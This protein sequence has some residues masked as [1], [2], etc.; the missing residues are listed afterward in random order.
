MIRPFV[1]IAPLPASLPCGA[2]P[3]GGG[4]VGADNSSSRFPAAAL[5]PLDVLL[6]KGGRPTHGK[7]KFFLHC[8]D[9]AEE[10]ASFKS[11]IDRRLLA[12][13]LVEQWL[14]RGGRFCVA[15]TN[16][17]GHESGY[18]RLANTEE[19]LQFTRRV[20]VRH[21]TPAITNKK[22]QDVQAAS[23]T[24]ETKEQEQLVQAKKN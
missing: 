12:R 13:R 20:L 18:F 22:K 1:R 14:D 3:G 8:N 4:L 19:A 10:Y 2:A 21:F 15:L 11:P 16:K 5:S 24:Q 23:A 9:S 6:K 17:D 7:K